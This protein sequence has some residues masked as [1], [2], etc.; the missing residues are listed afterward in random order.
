MIGNRVAVFVAV[1][2]KGEKGKATPEQMNFIGR[3]IF[4]GGLAGVARSVN[5]AKEI[6]TP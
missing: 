5:E 1:E 4:D 2:A 3:V 6:I